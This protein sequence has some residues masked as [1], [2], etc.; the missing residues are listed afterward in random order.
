MSDVT[1]ILTACQ[2]G[3]TAVRTQ[4]EK[5][6]QQART[7]NLPQFYVAMSGELCND[8]K[9]KNTRQLAGV[10]LKNCLD[11]NNDQ[12]AEQRAKEWLAL[13]AQ[14]RNQVKGSVV[15]GLGSSVQEARDTCAQVVAKIAR[16]ECPKK[17][18]PQ[19][20]PGLQQQIMKSNNA[21]LMQSST[22]AIGMCCEEV[23]P[24]AFTQDDLNKIL[25]AI[26]FAMTRKD[27]ETAV[28]GCKALFLALEFIE[29]NMKNKKERD[30]IMTNICNATNN[31]DARVR[32]MAFECMWRVAE[33]YYEFLGSYMQTLFKITLRCVSQDQPL[34][35]LQAFEFWLTICEV[36]AG[37]VEDAAE[38][39]GNLNKSAN[40]A[41]GAL[42]HLLPLIFTTLVKQDEDQDEDTWNIAKAGGVG[43]K[44]LTY[45]VGPECCQPVLH[46]IT[47]K[48][49][50]QNWRDREAAYVVVFFL[51]FYHSLTHTQSQKKTDT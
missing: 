39:K 33:I 12:L 37:I 24:S 1:Q 31:N 22:H 50:S 3:D 23:D 35:A 5:T 18:W 44:L 8:S 28:R 7:S 38:G 49:R 41:R 20:I 48:I 25:T 17:M 26:V 13:P 6:L 36:E 15:K 10:I 46:F 29:N 40:Y 47:Q 32:K 34:V 21:S 4:A 11:A 2:S 27:S 51:F 9:P 19:L 30:V 16:I 45:A 43:L 14:I 42:K